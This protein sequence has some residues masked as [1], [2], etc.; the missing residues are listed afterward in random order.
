MIEVPKLV[1]VLLV[2]FLVWYAMRWV[3]GTS[4]R[5]HRRGPASQ[6]Q[7]PHAGGQRQQAVEDLVACRVCGAYV[8]ANAHACGKPGCPQPL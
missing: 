2:G 7:P 5:V 6:P 8:A 3:N 1:L 4:P